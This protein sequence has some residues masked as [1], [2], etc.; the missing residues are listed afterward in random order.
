MRRVNAWVTLSGMASALLLTTGCAPDGIFGGKGGWR[1][2]TSSHDVAVGTLTRN[3]LLHVP[4]RR[5]TSSI[6]TTAPF[7]LYLIL[8]GT[9]GTGDD[10]RRVS[11]MDSAS[12]VGRFLVA[13]PNGV[14][15]GGGLYPSDWNAGACCG[16]AARENIDD[17]GF[18]SALVRQVS[19][20]LP[21]DAHRV[22]IA[23]FSD[24]GF[25]AYHAACKLSPMFAAIG[26]ISGS[27]KDANCAPGRA[28]PVVAIHGTSD[29]EVPYNDNALTAPPQ[30]VTGVGAQ[31]P[32]S[33]QFWIATN[34]CSAGTAFTQSPSVTRTTFGVCTGEVAFYTIQGET[35]AWPREPTGPGSQA[36]MSELRATSVLTQFL[37]RQVRR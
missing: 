27:L 28:V 19:A 14:T 32:P 5:P 36:P 7:P 12:E 11:Q 26:V 24:G 25:M 18:L 21:V 29:V 34:G 31:L 4:L 10:I 13:Y 35:H 9:S 16:A 30:P 6:G 15:G 8:H 3:Y 22:Y 17:L 23:G 37:S 20:H 33:I 1:P 2:G